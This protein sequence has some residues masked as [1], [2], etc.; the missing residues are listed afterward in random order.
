MAYVAVNYFLT[1]KQLT[2]HNT[3]PA[4]EETVRPSSLPLATTLE[5]FVPYA[6]FVLSALLFVAAFAILVVNRAKSL[7]NITIAILIAFMSAS[8]PTVIS[9]VGQGSR[10]T[11]NAGPEEIP[12]NVRVAT[13]SPTSVLISWNTDAA[14][15]GA[16][17]FGKVPL[18]TQTARIY[19]ADNQES[20]NKHT[21]EIDLPENKQSYE[22]E[23]LSGATWYDNGGKY[24]RFTIP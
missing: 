2:V 21:V 12:R 8:I 10:Q 19:V 24:I 15:V 22:F 1:I 7:K 18:T 13:V 6:P 4:H 5:P 16:V 11:A 23:I 20:A 14:R 3:A 9:Y 17:R